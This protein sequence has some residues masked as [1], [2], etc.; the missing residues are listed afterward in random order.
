M[1]TERT[2]NDGNDE[3]LCA[4]AKF[5][6]FSMLP[7]G[8][9]TRAIDGLLKTWFTPDCVCEEGNGGGNAFRR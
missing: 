1:Y 3:N 4:S 6:S 7:V 5:Y 2:P 8:R 9:E